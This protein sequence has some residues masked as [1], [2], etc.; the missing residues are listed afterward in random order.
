MPI[1][2]LKVIDDILR[3]L[4]DNARLRAEIE[5]LVARVQSLEKENED[6]KKEVETLRPKLGL[7]VETVKVLQIFFA[8]P[9]ELSRDEVASLAGLARGVADYHLDELRKLKFVMQS[10]AGEVA[11]FSIYPKGREFIMKN[12][13]A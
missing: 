11:R 5:K 8:S 1:P 3:G 12:K 4:P 9:H 7:D 13:L 6:L 10:H 2:G